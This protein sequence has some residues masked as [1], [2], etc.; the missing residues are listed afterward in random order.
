[1]HPTD[2][3]LLDRLAGA[4]RLAVFGSRTLTGDAVAEIILE[5]VDRL[6]PSAIVTAAEPSGVCDMARQIAAA[7]PLP[8]HLHFLDKGHRAAG[9]WEARSQSVYRNADAVL[10]IHDGASKGTA[11]ETALAFKMGLPH[12]YRRIDP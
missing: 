11:N 2:A 7:I 4:R 3:P 10:L 8:L 9:A 1:M 6:K 5:A 12:E